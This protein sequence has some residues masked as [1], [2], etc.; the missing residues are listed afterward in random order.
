MHAVLHVVALLPAAVGVG[1]LVG[2]RRDAGRPEILVAALMLAGMADVMTVLL[3]PPV[4]WFAVLVIVGI[5]LAAVR[6]AAPVPTARPEAMVSTHLALGVITTAVLVLLM[7]GIPSPAASPI[8]T[9]HVHGAVDT[10]PPAGECRAG[11]GDGDPRGG[12]AADRARLAASAPP[13]DHGGVD[14]RD[15]RDRRDL[16]LPRPPS[17]VPRPPSP[18]LQCCRDPRATPRP[19]ACTRRQAGVSARNGGL[20]GRQSLSGRSDAP[21]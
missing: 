15:V 12:R 8:I 21:P 17:P 9:S 1:A 4:L 7:P 5:V 18:S 16:T 14:R 2:M 13:R 6:R 19:P 10:M 11:A 3:L 20:G